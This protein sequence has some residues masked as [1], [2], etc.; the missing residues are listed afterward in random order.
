[1]PK[2]F[3]GENSKA[4]AARTRKTVAKEAETA[5]LQKKIE[6][7]Y[8]KDDDKQ[9]QKKQQRKEQQD[10]KKQ[11]QLDKKAEAKALLEKEMASLKST[12]PPPPAKVTRIQI[13]SMK[14]ANAAAKPEKQAPVTHLEMPLEEN[15]N[16]LQI[17]GEEARSV[18]EAI[19]ILSDKGADSDKH[20]EKRRKALYTAFEERRLAELKIENPSLKLSQLKQMIFKEWQ[21]SP[22]NPMNENA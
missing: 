12:K 7:E 4:V 18:S 19:N 5:K 1:M 6:E 9:V 15:I 8:W 17:E 2:K 10:K 16:R 20:P 14:Q 22:E 11:E 3:A 21:K 13:E